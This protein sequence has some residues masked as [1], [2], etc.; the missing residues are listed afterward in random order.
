MKSVRWNDLIVVSYFLQ[1][2]FRS[3]NDVEGG[4]WFH[5]RRKLIWKGLDLTIEKSI[6]SRIPNFI[7]KAKGYLHTGLSRK[8][9][10]LLSSFASPTLDVIFLSKPNNS[11]LAR[12]STGSSTDKNKAG[13]NISN[14]V[15]AILMSN[16]PRG[17]S[18]LGFWQIKYVNSY[19]LLNKRLS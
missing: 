8:K 18:S 3:P 7:I 16:S 11:W 5:P 19:C 14:S 9:W 15:V 1:N 12:I 13:R 2:L 6:H 10:Q 17:E 4:S